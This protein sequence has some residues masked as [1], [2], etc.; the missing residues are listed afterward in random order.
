M[1]SSRG[2][3]KSRLLWYQIKVYPLMLLLILK[4]GRALPCN[5]S[6]EGLVTVLQ[7]QGIDLR[8]LRSI[9][10]WHVSDLLSNRQR[11]KVSQCV[12]CR[13][14]NKLL[15]ESLV[16]TT[17]KAPCSIRRLSRFNQ[18]HSTTSA[19]ATLPTAYSCARFISQSLVMENAAASRESKNMPDDQWR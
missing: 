11:S 13:S 10:S 6:E 4:P 9:F 12:D 7:M 8:S 19:F 15:T 1:I 5:Y 17:I 2:R 3:E 18:M 14:I 16:A